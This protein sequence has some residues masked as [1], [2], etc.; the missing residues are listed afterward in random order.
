MQ[1]VR[2]GLVHHQE[3]YKLQKAIS[4]KLLNSVA[5]QTDFDHRNVL[6][7][8]EHYPVYTVGLRSREYSSDVEKMLLETGASFV[9]T[10]RGGLITF[11]GPGQL[12]AYPILYLKDFQLSMKCYIDDIENTV[13]SMCAEYGL[14]GKKSPHTGVWIGD[15]KIAAIGVH[16]SRYVTTHG[17]AINCN[18]DLSW[19]Q[20][21]IPCGIPDKGVTSFSKELRRNFSVQEGMPTFLRCFEK[22]F[23]CHLFENSDIGSLQ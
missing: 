9:R 21:I 6:L 18:V 19:Y 17:V 8:Q 5:R 11:H 12:V 20:H 4:A 16:G 22:I 15:N 3:S 13:I 10:N 1:V 7:L 2:L 23:N 14:K